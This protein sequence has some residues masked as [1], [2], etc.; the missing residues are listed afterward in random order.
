MGFSELMTRKD[1]MRRQL[2]AGM[3]LFARLSLGKRVA[4]HAGT[5]TI[6]GVSMDTV[7]R[8]CTD[9]CLAQ[10]SLHT[11]IM[12]CFQSGSREACSAVESLHDD[13]ITLHGEV[14]ATSSSQYYREKT[15]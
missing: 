5:H 11:R 15:T 1:V 7:L 13:D 12:A 4:I 3:G 9:T 2:G 6:H 10:A 14:T 8:L